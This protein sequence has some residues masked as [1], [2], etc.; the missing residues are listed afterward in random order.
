MKKTFNI[1]LG[2]II[3]HI[4]DDAFNKLEA[5]LSKLRSQFTKTSGGDEILNDVETRMAELFRE[6]ISESKQVINMKDLDEVI[7]IMGKPEDYLDEE[8]GAGFDSYNH[9]DNYGGTKKI[10]RDV[11]NRI[12]GGVSS[13]LAAYFNIDPLWVRLLFVVMLFAGFG[14]LLYLILWVVV[15]AARTTTEKLQM[16]GKPVT[17][18]NIE[19]FVKEEGA[20]LGASM[21]QLGDK[22][23]HYNRGGQSVLAAFFSG[24]FSI[25]RLIFRFIFKIIGIFFLV[26]GII[27]LI[28]LGML[29][30]IGI[31][32]D[33]YR[34]DLSELGDMIQLIAVDSSAYNGIMIGSSLLFLGP[35]LLLIYYGLRII[36][37]M[38][39]LNSGMRRGIGLLS[40]AGFLTLLISGIQVAQ[41]FEEGSSQTKEYALPSK[42]GMIYLEIKQDAILDQLPNRYRNDDWKIIDGRSYFTDIELNVR[43]ST[44]GSSYLVQKN[45]ARGYDRDIAR[46]NAQNTEYNIAIDTGVALLDGYFTLPKGTYYRAQKIDLVVYLAKGDTLYLSPGTKR[47]IYDIDNV[48]NIWDPEMEGHHWIMTDRGLYCTDCEGI[49]D[50]YDPWAEEVEEDAADDQ[51][52][53]APKVLIEDDMIRI[54]EREVYYQEDESQVM[55][56]FQT[57]ELPYTLI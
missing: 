57:S 13:G 33:G 25:L 17:L 49:N 35:L 15:P 3:F 9:Q 30:F 2:G 51:S 21:S 16:R 10:H 24:I 19:N 55:A 18:S 8:S 45:A 4:D 1:N 38:E 7:S 22:A 40:L 20:A 23:R 47:I 29:F 53:K 52:K 44:T 36:F 56:L 46:L 5:Y 43:R 50:D 31:K 37:G 12:I 6:R 41:E 26:I 42:A 11:D 34:Y 48:Q 32:L 14:F 28:S 54:E 27:I 39:P